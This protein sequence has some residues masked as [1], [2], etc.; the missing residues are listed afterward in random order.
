MQAGECLIDGFDFSAHDCGD[1]GAVSALEVAE[2]EE[3][4][5]VWGDLFDAVTEGVVLG[6]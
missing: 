2:A 6:V 4:P 3:F 1:I 5:I